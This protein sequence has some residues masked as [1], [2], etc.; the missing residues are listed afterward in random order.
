MVILLAAVA[1]VVFDSSEKCIEYVNIRTFLF[2][3]ACVVFFCSLQVVFVVE[4][5]KFSIMI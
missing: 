5:S 3:Y 2:C 4:T 1:V